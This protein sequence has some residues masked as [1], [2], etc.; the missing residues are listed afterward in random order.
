MSKQAYFFD[1]DGTLVKYHTNHWLPGARKHLKHVFNAGH[2]IFLLTA[3]NDN[4][5]E[6]KTWSPQR[7][8]DSILKDLD[9]D[10]V[11]YVVLFGV[12]SP[13]VLVDDSEVKIIKRQTN[14]PWDNTK[15][16]PNSRVVIKR[17]E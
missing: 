4:W 2:Q 11:R 13:R 7:T 5:D 10:G 12:R 15:M 8:R 14:Q 1:I 9:D 16:D 6:G 17:A 3:R